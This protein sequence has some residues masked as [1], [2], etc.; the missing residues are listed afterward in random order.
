MCICSHQTSVSWSQPEFSLHL[1]LRFKIHLLKSILVQR[2]VVSD[3]LI[4]LLCYITNTWNDGN[5][6]KSIKSEEGPGGQGTELGRG[7]DSCCMLQEPLFW[8]LSLL[9]VGIPVS[10]NAYCIN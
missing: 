4:W 10:N 6:F 9:R 7:A 1:F 5:L 2:R 8:F 3:S